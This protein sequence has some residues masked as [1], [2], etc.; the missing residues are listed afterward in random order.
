LSA[1]DA[2]FLLSLHT[3]MEGFRNRYKGVGHGN[4]GRMQPAVA[5]QQRR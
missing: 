1:G 2:A 5:V 4:C 3:A